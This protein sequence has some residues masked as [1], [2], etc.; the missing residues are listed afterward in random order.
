MSDA[1]QILAHV[2]AVLHSQLG[3]GGGAIRLHLADGDLTMEGE[4]DDIAA[5]KLSLERVAAVRGIGRIVDRL[6]VKPAERMSDGQIRDHLRDSLLQEP[7]LGDCDLHE[8]VKGE[9]KAVR[10][11]PVAAGAIS[12]RVED[13]VI[14]LDGDVPGLSRKRLAGVL[15]WW[16]PGATDVV[17]GIGVTPPQEDSESEILEA[18]RLVLER[19]PFVDAS[20]IRVDVRDAV[21]TLTGTVPSEAEKAM[22]E[23][24]AWY[25]FAVDKVDNDLKVA[26]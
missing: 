10:T 4:V 14:T 16:V 20:R 13:G 9:R 5:K 12:I 21:V 19:D 2:R 24:D 11:L 23:H 25:V 17:N 8:W 1:D 22:A 26:A 7:A 6:H 15:A 18:V 3:A